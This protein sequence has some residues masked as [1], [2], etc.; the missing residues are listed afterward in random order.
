MGYLRSPIERT[1]AFGIEAL[2]YR[3]AAAI[4][5]VSPG[6]V[7]LLSRK[8]S[9]TGRVELIPNGVQIDHFCPS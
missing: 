2:A 6:L 1:I 3:G 9:A 5:T 8:A 4:T 7:D